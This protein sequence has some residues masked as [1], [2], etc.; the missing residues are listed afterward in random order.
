VEAL[1]YVT[2]N[3]RE[4]GEVFT[5]L[6]GENCRLVLGGRFSGMMDEFRIYSS[7]IETATLSKYSG[8]SG[9]AESRTLDLG[10]LNSRVLKIEAFGGRT[11]GLERGDPLTHNLIGQVRNEYAGNGTLR[12]DDHAEMRFY[13]RTSNS[14]YQWQDVPWIPINPGRDLPDTI[15]GRFVQ[16]AADFYPSGNGE[17]SPYLSE[18]RVI[19]Q[20]AEPPSP[21]TQVAAVAR[22]GAVEISWRA[23]PSR[24]VGGYLVYFGTAKGEYFGDPAIAEPGIYS[25]INV[26]NRNSVRIEGLNNGTLYYFAVAAYNRVEQTENIVIFHEPGRLAVEPG[27]FSREVAARPLSM[28]Q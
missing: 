1:E 12:F 20:A 26:G 10:H 11:G 4:S 18:L 25:P 2:S 7:Y 17:T 5:P 27:E 21:P 16:L 24:N 9:R 13:I 23:S 28:A 6:I 8:K 3:N 22:D 19:Y 15:R 14:P